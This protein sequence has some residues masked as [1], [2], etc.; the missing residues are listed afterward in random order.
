MRNADDRAET[1]TTKICAGYYRVSIDGHH[2][3]MVRRM[4][5]EWMPNVLPNLSRWAS[6]NARELGRYSTKR[7]AVRE[8]EIFIGT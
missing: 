5:G 2:V 1:K 3:G 8:I 6:A 4:D 7:E